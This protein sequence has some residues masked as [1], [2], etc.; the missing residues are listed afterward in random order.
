MR[1]KKFLSSVLCCVLMGQT[2]LSCDDSNDPGKEESSA[3]ILIETAIKNPDGT[4]GSSYIQ[5]ISDFSKQSLD[6][7]N[8]LQVGFDASV[9]VYGNSVYV[10]PE[11]GKDGTQEVVKYTYNGMNLLTKSAALQLPP[12]SGA[13]N[14]VRESEEKAYI[15]LYNL[16]KVLVFVRLGSHSGTDK[17]QPLH[18]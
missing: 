7:K 13:F 15:S 12:M 3:K 4:S 18:R 6:N 14:M 16:G 5:F 9:R 10:L 8:G 1:T 11:F 2:L 17:R